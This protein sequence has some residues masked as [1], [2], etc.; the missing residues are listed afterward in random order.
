MLV[1]SGWNL[2]YEA[3]DVTSKL[4]LS[5]REGVE[6]TY[7]GIKATVDA[8]RWHWENG[9]AAVAGDTVAYESMPLGKGGDGTIL[10]EIFLSGWAMP[11]G[12]SFDLELLAK[13]CKEQDRYTFFL[14]SQPLT[15]PG[16]VASPPNVMAIF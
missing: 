13:R 4:E 6:R 3:L 1:R 15:L 10:H 14:S 11:I 5:A 2:Q 16:G 7:I 12:E 8:A 9:F